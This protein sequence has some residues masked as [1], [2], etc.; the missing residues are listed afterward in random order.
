M[1]VAL[2]AAAFFFSG[3]V[4]ADTRFTRPSS[5]TTSRAGIERLHLPK[6]YGAQSSDWLKESF[7]SSEFVWGVYS[8]DSSHVWVGGEGTIWFFNGASWTCQYNDSSGYRM[9]GI[10]GCNSTHVW[11]VGS[12]KRILFFNGTTWSAQFTGTVSSYS[13]ICGL[14]QTHVWACGDTQVA[15]FDGQSWTDAGT[16]GVTL[17]TISADTPTDV[18]A[19]GGNANTIRFNGISWSKVT[20]PDNATW[21]WGVDAIDATHVWVGGASETGPFFYNGNSWQ[22]FGNIENTH[23]GA[24]RSTAVNDVWFK[25]YDSVFHYNGSSFSQVGS[26]IE[27]VNL[28]DLSLAQDGSVWLVGGTGDVYTLAGAS[29]YT[30]SISS[31]SPSYG[32]RGQTLDVEI[33]GSHTGFKNGASEATFSGSGI[34]VNSTIVLNQATAIANITIDASAPLGTRDVNVITGSE[35]PTALK[36]RFSVTYRS[37]YFAEGTCRPGFDPY[38]CIQNIGDSD[39]RIVITYMKGDGGSASDHID[40]A[41]QSRLTLNPKATLG[42]GDDTSHDFSTMVQCTNGQPILAER[43]MYFKYNGYTNLGWTG[44]H[45]VIGADSPGEAFG[46]AEGTCRPGFDTYFCILN[47]NSSASQV[48]VIYMLGDGQLTSQD[49]TV[50]AHS[51]ATVSAKDTLG[52]GDDPAHDFSALVGT[53]NNQDIV[54]E[55]PMYF[56]YSGGRNCNWTGGSDVVGT[57]YASRYFYFAEGTC[58]PGFDPYI[59]IQNPSPSG[60]DAAVTITYMKGDGSSASDHVSVAPHSRVTV[61]P[62]ATLGEGSDPSHDF[63]TVVQCTNGQHIIAERP[64][65]FN[66]QGRWNGGHDVI[67]AM[68]PV[69]VAGFAEG[70]CR[71]GFDTYFC[72]LNPNSNDSKVSVIY[73]LGDGE[74]TGQ[75]LVVPAHSRATVISKDKLGEGDDPSHDFSTLVGTDN[76]QDIVVERPMYFNYSGGRNCNWTGGTDVVGY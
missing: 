41:P 45:D 70:T 74:V 37:F 42:E 21:Y 15:T 60:T 58:R 46:F 65:Y 26:T 10:W 53:N 44:G 50:P 39:A 8:L 29:P 7:P 20:P 64:M 9:T 56:N 52:E 13:G 67:G 24:I 5:N 12:N 27:N 16:P 48:S 63:S 43:P 36:K 31:C 25:T 62:R 4:L 51:R 3:N 14:D 2:L 6:R 1:T 30:P 72:I 49:L 18:W 61:N 55:R 47:P 22:Q 75:D 33:T 73:M 59:C 68:F 23:W 76:N 40:V 17:Q 66:Y 57:M 34:A 19:V 69:P 32:A 35:V 54:V 71:P 28:E 11:A 38:I